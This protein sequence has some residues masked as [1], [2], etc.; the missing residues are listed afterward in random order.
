[1]NVTDPKTTKAISDANKLLIDLKRSNNRFLNHT[2]K[3]EDDIQKT[4]QG[5]NQSWKETEKKLHAIDRDIA[6]KTDLAILDF[7][8]G[9]TE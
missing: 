2:Q 3:I 1:M 5:M 8:A 6:E 9:E 7:A 4:V